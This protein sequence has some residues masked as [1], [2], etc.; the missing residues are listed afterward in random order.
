ME[1][2]ACGYLMFQSIF[3][4]SKLLIVANCVSI[5]R[6][7]HRT[8]LNN[9]HRHRMCSFGMIRIRIN[10][11]QPLA[12]W[13]IKGIKEFLPTEM[14]PQRYHVMWSHLMELSDTGWITVQQSP[15]SFQRHEKPGLHCTALFKTTTS[16]KLLFTSHTYTNRSFD[17]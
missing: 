6:W 1:I 16:R 8:S 13:C 17:P 12:S 11:P 4:S 5:T 15:I 14:H 9:N 3:H 10:A 2:F 7:R